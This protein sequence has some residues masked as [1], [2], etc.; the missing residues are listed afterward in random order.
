M[1]FMVLSRRVTERFS[2]EDFV[3]LIESEAN[4]ARSLYADGFI[5]NIWH[6]AD[7]GGACLLIEADS[8]S[9]TRATL[10]TLPLVAAGML[11]LVS[12][13]PLKPYRGFGPMR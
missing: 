8:E 13:V 12:V 7:I 3:P 9:A 2:D 11:E 6:R 1:Q 4:C 10:A 5:R